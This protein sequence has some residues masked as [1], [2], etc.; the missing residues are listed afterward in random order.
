[1]KPRSPELP[2][3]AF[4]D[5]YR[6]ALAYLLEA[7]AFAATL[8]CSNDEFACQFSSLQNSGISESVLRSLF[9]EGLIKHLSETTRPDQKCRTFGIAMNAHFTKLSC[10]MLTSKGI[11]LA[12]RLKKRVVSSRSL[13]LPR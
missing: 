12:E 5:R 7:K 2:N 6:D 1:M 3:S 4:I 9:H 13:I 8:N 11:A 10:F